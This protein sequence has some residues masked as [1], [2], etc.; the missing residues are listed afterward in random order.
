MSSIPTQSDAPHPDVQK[1][2]ADVAELVAQLAVLDAKIEELGDKAKE[3]RQV[4]R[5]EFRAAHEARFSDIDYKR[6]LVGAKCE[7]AVTVKDVVTFFIRS[8][9]AATVYAVDKFIGEPVLPDEADRTKGVNMGPVSEAERI[10]LA[11]LV[12]VHLMADPTAKRQ[13]MEAL[14]PAHRLR[15]I[16]GLPE[17]L[18][19]RVA[20][21][22]MLLQSYLN[23]VLEIELGNF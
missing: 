10:M 7:H 11:W 20:D 14:P 2:N 22:C 21:E 12:G 23:V 5:H 15:A 18:L 17:N 9:S 4:M 13:D 6:A 1:R 16:R 3:K 19:R 8:P